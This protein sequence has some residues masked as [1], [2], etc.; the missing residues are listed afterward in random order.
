MTVSSACEG[1]ENEKIT[2]KITRLQVESVFHIF[3]R[4]LAC[5]FLLCLALSQHTESED[6]DIFKSAGFAGLC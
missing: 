4:S 3:F 2:K 1:G 5:C 6:T